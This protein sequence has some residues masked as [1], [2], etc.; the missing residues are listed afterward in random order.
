MR[1][2]AAVA[3]AVA[4]SAVAAAPAQGTERFRVS[5]SGTW[6]T[7]A[8]AT[9]TT[10]YRLADPQSTDMIPFTG[11][12]DGVETASFQTLRSGTAL[13]RIERG[14][15]EVEGTGPPLRLRIPLDR[16]SNAGGPCKADDGER[17]PDCG[18]RDLRLGV[19]VFNRGAA[20]S[21]GWVKRF[22][23]PIGG[24]SYGFYTPAD[25]YDRCQLVELQDG[26]L[27]LREEIGE[28]PDFGVAKISRKA[29]MDRRRKTLVLRGFAEGHPRKDTRD[30]EGQGEVITV[31]YRL[32]WTLTLRR[33]S[34][35]SRG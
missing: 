23:D 27:R 14:K 9:D 21:F 33:V 11:E 29:L 31:D 15:L 13:A 6:K 2:R 4:A 28:G 30:A 5:L 20:L 7:Q 8:H 10:C 12:F 19:G 26:L 3:L 17:S 18:R 34:R 24:S 16:Q 22:T 1:L 35:R 25:P 32:D